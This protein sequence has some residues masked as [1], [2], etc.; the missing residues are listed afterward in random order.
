MPCYY[1]RPLLVEGIPW[2]LVVEEIPWLLPVEEIPKY[3]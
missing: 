2:L 1:G 3:L